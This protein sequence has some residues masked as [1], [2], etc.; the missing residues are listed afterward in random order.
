MITCP[1]KDSQNIPLSYK[2]IRKKTKKKW[3]CKKKKSHLWSLVHAVGLWF[4]I[5]WFENLLGRFFC[6]K[7]W[8]TWIP[9][10]QT[11][12]IPSTL[13]SWMIQSFNP[14][15]LPINWLMT[16]NRLIFRCG[17]PTITKPST[18][19]TNSSSVMSV[20]LWV[21][22]LIA[23]ADRMQPCG[24]QDTALMIRN[25]WLDFVGTALDLVS[26]FLRCL[27][28]KGISVFTRR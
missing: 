23:S 3:K 8:S 9:G 14:F 24:V 4:K 18:Q 17:R 12:N 11:S 15:S 7:L 6:K 13:R 22:R 5:F 20:G 28:T 10:S 16:S 1:S 2:T 19:A 27:N 25:L 26:Q 21:K